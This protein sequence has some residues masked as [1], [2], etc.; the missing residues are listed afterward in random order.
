MAGLVVVSE[1]GGYAESAHEVHAVAVDAA[2]RVVDRIGEPQIS[3]WRSASKPFQLEASLQIL[4]RSATDALSGEQIAIGAASHWG[5]PGHLVAVRS[6][7]AQFGGDE[8]CLYCGVH[9]PGRDADVVALIRAG[10]APS[11]IHNNCSGKH[12]YMA[13]SSNFS[14]WDA[15]Y[16]SPNHPLQQRIRAIVQAHTGNAVIDAVIDGCGVPCWVLPIDGMARAWAQIAARM[17]AN[18]GDLARIGTA[19]NRCWWH[20]SGT[21]A[22]DGALIRTATRPIVAKVGA[23][24]L[25]CLAIPDA[26]V[27]I[28]VKVASGSDKA[29]AIA[30][31]AVLD[32][33]YPGLVPA[34]ADRPWRTVRNWVGTECGSWTDRWS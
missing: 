3:T 25:I 33:W 20:M 17:A 22:L 14:G 7:L 30:V 13:W 31:H 11:A 9:P 8:T 10:S 18:D 5:E 6:I 24:G 29:R 19:M 23:E 32:R 15:D 34:G 1:R 21:N 26:G 27:G 12:A 16:R 2:G 4:P 28:A